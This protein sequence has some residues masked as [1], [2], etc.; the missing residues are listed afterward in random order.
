MG[1]SQS[2]DKQLLPALADL[3]S[4]HPDQNQGKAK[5]FTSPKQQLLRAFLNSAVFLHS[6]RKATLKALPLTDRE[7]DDRTLCFPIYMKLLMKEGP[8]T[9]CETT[10]SP[11][12]SSLATEGICHSQLD[13]QVKNSQ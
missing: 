11:R 5:D 9:H 13:T 6:L 1:C 4:L 8:T 7:E 10:I 3:E 12:P 2:L